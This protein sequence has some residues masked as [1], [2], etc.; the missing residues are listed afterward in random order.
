MAGEFEPIESWANGL[1]ARLE[2]TARRALARE[3]A[4]GLRESQQRRISDQVN[5]DGSGFAPR[6]PA[7][8]GKAG[9][10]KR[11]MF[12]KLRTARFLKVE[13]SANAAVVGFVGQVERIA[14]VHQLGLRDRVKPGG[15]EYTYP[16]RELLGISAEDFD[17]IKDHVLAHIA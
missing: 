14:H 10:I 11:K 9:K 13:A 17:R 4:K 3:I 16:V 5:P 6:K 15:P 2:P 7:L 12:T 1:I 8:R